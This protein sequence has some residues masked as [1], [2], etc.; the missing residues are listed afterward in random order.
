[1]RQQKSAIEWSQF[2][3][4]S[5]GLIPVI[6]QDYRNNEVLML[7]YMN[8]EAFDKTV[9][10]GRMTYWSRSRQELWLKGETSGHFQYVKRLS[11]DCDNDTLLAYVVQ[12]GAA[13]HTGNRSCFY[14]DLVKKEYDTIDPMNTLHRLY[15]KAKEQKE[16]LIDADAVRKQAADTLYHMTDLMAEYQ[17]SWED[18]TE[19]I[20]K[21]EKKNKE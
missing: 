11:I 13:C 20:D 6:V 1:M 12:V 7:A 8:E 9:K 16:A 5:D 21:R 15:E 3:L 10:T 19:E 2:K 18:V 17:V 14:R 4:N